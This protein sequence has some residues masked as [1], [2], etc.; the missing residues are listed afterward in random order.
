MAVKIRSLGRNN[1]QHFQHWSAGVGPHVP[2]S[3][4]SDENWGGQSHPR[5]KGWEAAWFSMPLTY[6]VAFSDSHAG[7][8]CQQGWD[9]GMRSR[10]CL[11]TIWRQ[12]LEL[13]S[14]LSQGPGRTGQISNNLPSLTTCA[15]VMIQSP[16]TTAECLPKA[17]TGHVIPAHTGLSG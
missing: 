10:L 14:T 16:S 1:I 11:K 17:A 12:H 8:N 2:P 13:V 15:P 5:H 3:P 9:A 6:P 7:E 4:A